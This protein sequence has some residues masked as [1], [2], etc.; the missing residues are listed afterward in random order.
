VQG[1]AHFVTDE[2]IKGIRV[3]I[4]PHREGQDASVHVEGGSLSLRVML[5]DEI[6]SRHQFGEE[7]LGG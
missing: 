5:N 6:F 1:V 3:K 7:V 2:H 4:L